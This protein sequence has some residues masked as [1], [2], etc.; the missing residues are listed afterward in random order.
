[1]KDAV[2][3][4][5]WNNAIRYHAG[6]LR[7]WEKLEKKKKKKKKCWVARQTNGVA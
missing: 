5:K 1:M 6:D 2:D 4:T 7:L 3:I